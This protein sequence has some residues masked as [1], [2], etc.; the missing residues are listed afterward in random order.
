MFRL[1]FFLLFID[2]LNAQTVPSE[3]TVDWSSAIKIIDQHEMLPYLEIFEGTL[4]SDG[5][6]PNDEIFRNILK[7]VEPTGTEV[8]L[9]K[10]DFLFNEPI[11]LPPG[12]ILKGYNS[13][14][15]RF[16]MDLKGS[17]N[18]FVIKG[19]L[20]N[21][22]K[23]NITESF[24]KGQNFII[25]DDGS[26]WSSGQWFKLTI[27]DRDLITSDWARNSV[28]QI[29]KIAA[30]SGNTIFLEEA[31][32]FQ[33]E[34]S[35][36]PVVTRM[37]PIQNVGIEC[38]NIN[39]LDNSSPE[40]TSNIYFENA[41]NCWV[42]GVQSGNCNFGHITISSSS[43]IQVKRSYFHSAFEYGGGGRGYGVVLQFTS[44]E[45]LLENNIFRHL[46]HSILLQAGANGNVISYNYS[47]D[48]Y[49]SSVPTDAAGD[50][51][52]H[53]NYVFANLFEQNIC[54]NIVIDNSHGPNG[55]FNTFFRNR[56]EK[57][58]IS[59]GSNNSPSQNIV[60]NEITN[61]LIPYS[62]VNY[63]IKG[64]DQFTYSNNNKGK[65]VPLNTVD[66]PEKSLVYSSKPTFLSDVQ[67]GGIGSPNTLNSIN[68]PAYDRWKDANPLK[69]ACVDSLVLTTNMVNDESI[70]NCYPSPFSAE[71]I[72]ESKT[73]LSDFKI[74]D[75][76]GRIVFK[77]ENIDQNLKIN[78]SN[79]PSGFYFVHISSGN[80]TLKT[81][82]LIKI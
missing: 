32:R 45:C 31:L 13:Y 34:T 81:V 47:Y 16:L 82:K 35:D 58:G 76:I 52:L 56:S 71:L 65:I 77:I 64:A 50:M 74:F 25:V 62:L 54:Q 48:P 5:Q 20:I 39:R 61:N 7:F 24:V 18:A 78:T 68:I 51:V 10:G 70:I 30:V 41:V 44:G 4:Y 11:D 27:D 22:D 19:E 69:G 38:I 1:V 36:L 43:T 2:V 59:F 33:A 26:S 42:T 17:G 12:T 29:C 9:P 75:G 40:Q 66:L 57:Y 60:G 6:T 14:E 8:L 72:I 67:W 46:R 3:R 63:T 28:G 21:S 79:W 55:P 80:E 15:T 53:G 49:W 23:S 37:D 73:Q